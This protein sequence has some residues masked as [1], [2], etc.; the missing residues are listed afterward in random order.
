[1]P[2][3]DTT[4]N[5]DISDDDIN[6]FLRGLEGDDETTT[7]D[8]AETVEPV[9]GETDTTV[10]EPTDTEPTTPEPAALWEFDDGVKVSREQAHTLAQFDAWLAANPE[11]AQ[12]IAGVVQGQYTLVPRSP[13]GE[14]TDVRTPSPT[15]ASAPD[16]LD[17]DDPVQK[18]IWT[19]LQTTRAQLD[20]ASEILTRHEQ[21]IQNTTQ[22]T[23]TALVNRAAQ[24]YATQHNLNSDEIQQVREAAARLNIIESLMNPYDPITGLPR[25]ID[26]VDAI[27]KALDTAYWT[28]PEFRQRAMQEAMKNRV[29]D[30]RKKQ[31][32][33]SL[34]G[35]SGSVPRQPAT[36]A[37]EQERRE[38]MIREAAAMMNGEGQE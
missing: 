4:S 13:S 26:P 24:E 7:G 32:L 14:E 5:L 20:A 33:T 1:M 15:P 6:E 18:R 21:Q 12:Q 27:H 3:D 25:Q 35:T 29:T 16:D 22:N 11:M 10:V 17:L 38:A 37:T 30:L 34:G 2:P 31:K 36:P 8:D 28:V 19:E 23:T 9:V